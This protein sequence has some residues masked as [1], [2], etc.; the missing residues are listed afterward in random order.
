MIEEYPIEQNG[1]RVGISRITKEGMFLKILCRCDIDYEEDLHIEI[2]G[3]NKTVD[4]GVC[5]PGKF[6]VELVARLLTRDLPEHAIRVQLSKQEK[7]EFYPVT[8]CGP[9]DGLQLLRTGRFQVRNGQPGI[10]VAKSK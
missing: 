6:G 10:V 7:D 3:D 1:V 8:H 9:F 5:V 4:L 2:I